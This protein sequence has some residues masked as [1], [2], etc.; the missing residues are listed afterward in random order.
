V[1]INRRN[2]LLNSR[3]GQTFNDLQ[4]CGL[5][6]EIKNIEVRSHVI[7]TGGSGQRQHSDIQREPENNLADGPTI[8]F[9]DLNQFRTRYWK[10]Q[11]AAR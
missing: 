8:A 9:G 10:A 2:G 1:G 4:F 11:A 7:S 5:Q 3:H 6:R